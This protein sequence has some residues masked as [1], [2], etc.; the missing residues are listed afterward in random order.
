MLVLIALHVGG[1]TLAS[2]RLRENLPR[3][4]V[5]GRKRPPAPDDV[6]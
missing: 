6:A 1:V 4:M 5:T 3:A 2:F